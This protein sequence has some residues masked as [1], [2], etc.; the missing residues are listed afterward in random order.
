MNISLK[1]SL[2][3]GFTGTLTLADGSKVIV[4]GKTFNET[5]DKLREKHQQ[6][7]SVGTQGRKSALEKFSDTPFNS[8]LQ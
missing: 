6:F 3:E 2:K 1:G 5:I 7:S 4:E 8:G